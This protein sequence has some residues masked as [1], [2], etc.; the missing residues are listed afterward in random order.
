MNYLEA[1]ELGEAWTKDH[2]ISLD[3]WRSVIAVLLQRISV[4]EMSNAELTKA[5][6]KIQLENEALSL[7]LGIK[8]QDFRLPPQPQLKTIAD[9][10]RECESDRGK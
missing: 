7:D 4:L 1:K 6:A 9:I 8:D 3:G 5:L 10:I 2:D